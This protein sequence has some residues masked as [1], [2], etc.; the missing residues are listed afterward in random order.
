MVS[1]DATKAADIGF[2]WQGLL[3]AGGNSYVGGGTNFSAAATGGNIIDLAVAAGTLAARRHRPTTTATTAHHAVEPAR[4]RPEHRLG[5]Q[6]QR[7][8]HAGRA[9][10]LP[11]DQHRRQ[12]RCR[13]RT[14]SRWTTRKPRSSSARTSRW[15][16][17]ASPTPAPR[18]G[19]VNPFQTV[20]RQDVGIT[21][22]IKSQIGEN[23]TV[24]MTIYEE[25]SS[26]RP[27]A[28]A[29]QV[30]NKTSV[31]T[32]VTVDDGAMIVL[33]GLIKDEYN[34]NASACRCSRASRILGNLFKSSRPHAPQA[35]T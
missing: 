1:V 29:S 22:R 34:D 25:N 27:A 28:P 15:S 13:R 2:Q 24:R 20:E 12:R 7:H 16:P 32:Y 21:L 26:R 5:A 3:G 4:Q 33:G 18:S 14:W 11:R 6:D 35:A 31:E 17:A 8:L 30:T 19:T 23:G 10:P 9:G